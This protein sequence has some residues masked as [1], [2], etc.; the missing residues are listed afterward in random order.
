MQNPVLSHIAELDRKPQVSRNT[1]WSILNFPQRYLSFESSVIILSCVAKS[2][3][4]L[5]LIITPFF[6]VPR[7]HLQHS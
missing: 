4:D 6:E 1:I 3:Y 2:R 5:P 7:K